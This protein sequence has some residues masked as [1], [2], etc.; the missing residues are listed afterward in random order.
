M[1]GKPAAQFV[2]YLVLIALYARRR[3]ATSPF[4]GVES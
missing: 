4:V 1:T 2:V 3:P